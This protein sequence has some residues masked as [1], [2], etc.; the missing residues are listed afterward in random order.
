[1]KGST[2]YR[3]IQR[4]GLHIG[5][6]PEMAAAVDPST[7]IT[8]DHD[9]DVLPEA[10]RRLTVRQYADH[11]DDLAYR[12]HAAGVRP[13]EHVVIYKT[14]N[15]DHWM[16]AAA[17]SRIGAVVVNL[18]PALDATTVGV[19]LE[20]VGRPTLLTDGRKLD[21]LDGVPL[22]DLTRRVITSA[23]DRPGAVSLGELAAR[24]GCGRC[25]GRWTRPPSSPTPPAPPAS[26]NS[27]S[28]PPYPGGTAGAA[29]AAAGPQAQEGDR[30]HPRALRA[31]PDGRRD[32]FGAAQA[33]PGAAA[34][35]DGPRRRRRALPRPP[36]RLRRGAAQLPHGM[37][38]AHRRPPDAVRLREGL[39]QHLRRHPPRHHELSC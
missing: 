34:A 7:P 23:A 12:L 38:T 5:L 18:S 1:M 8:L 36:A 15:A 19:L 11:V 17:V 39:L 27:S 22:A 21:L 2:A 16:L 32:V 4:R 9:L 20:R 28:T 25:C 10:G 30:R 31:L 24:P 37:G 6:L 26:P 14:A 29:V 35:R 13:G 33:V 3:S